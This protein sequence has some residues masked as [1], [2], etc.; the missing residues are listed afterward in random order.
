MSEKIPEFVG[1][2]FQDA[3]S[4]R[5]DLRALGSV[6]TDT[7]RSSPATC[8]IFLLATGLVSLGVAFQLPGTRGAMLASPYRDARTLV[9]VSRDGSTQMPVAG[10]S[11]GEFRHW[12]QTTQG[13]FSDLAFYQIVRKE[14]HTG[15]GAAVELSVVRA[16]G[17]LV[18]LLQSSRFS[19]CS[20]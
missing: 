17:N 15:H 7:F 13:V 2:A 8:L 18:S 3:F 19:D 6:R 5:D 4:L 9:V 20:S 10:I 11:L 1:G 14:L 12:Q 16:S